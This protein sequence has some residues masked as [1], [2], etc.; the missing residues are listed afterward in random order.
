YTS[1]VMRNLYS[2]GYIEMV[3]KAPTVL[4]WLYDVADKPWRA[5]RRRLA[6]DRL[7][8]LPLVRYINRYKP[9]LI[10]ST[11]FLPAEIVSW[12]WCKGKIS[13]R[14]AIVVTDFDA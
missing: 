13:T 6:F 2:K 14:Q 12:L 8:S 3:N 5:E 4:G 9:D 10:V 1:P 11:H 7:N